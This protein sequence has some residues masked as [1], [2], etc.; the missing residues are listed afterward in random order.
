MRSRYIEVSCMDSIESVHG[1]IIQHGPL[2]DRIYL[3]RYNSSDPEAVIQSLNDIAAR[4]GYGKII[5]KI[6]AS[7]WKLFKEYGYKT[8]AV[9][10]GLFNG[11]A[12]GYFAAK[13]MGKGRSINQAPCLP[14]N[15]HDI[16]GS[17]Q[18]SCAGSKTRVINCN[19]IDAPE[20]SSFYD[21]V[22]ETYP[23]PIHTPRYIEEMMHEGTQ[24][25]CIKLQ[26]KIAA[27][28]AAEIDD[29]YQF[30]EMTDFATLPIH[31]GKG[32]AG[33]LLRHMESELVGTG[34]K[35]GFTIAREQSQA[36]NTVFKNAEYKLGG[37]LINNTNICGDIQNM[38]VWYKKF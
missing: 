34:I 26:G 16:S 9:I 32:F 33:I 1:S 35:T 17:R 4:F 13:F 23:F 18:R 25:Y 29:K 37:L 2:N 20:I 15:N 27:I 36:M 31:H 10:P 19:L 38:N 22:F 28:A 6:P 8:E 14:K 3:M 24:Y 7:T 21:F 12:D 5:A 30:V 11:S